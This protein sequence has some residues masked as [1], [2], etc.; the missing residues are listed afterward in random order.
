MTFFVERLTLRTWALSI[1]PWLLAR[2]SRAARGFVLDGSPVA[3]RVA[4]ASASLFGV[5]LERLRWRVDDVRDEHGVQVW[6]KTAYHDL[7]EVQADVMGEPVFREFVARAKPADRLPTYLAKSIATVTVSLFDPRSL[8]RALWLVQVCGWAARAAGGGAGPAVLFAGRRPWRR[9]IER[10]AA[11]AGLRL[12]PVAPGASPRRLLRRLLGPR[13]ILAIRA[14]RSVVARWR[15]PAAEAGGGPAGPRVA[16]EYYGHLNLEHPE[17][18]SDLFF[19][20]QGAL[21]GRDLLVSFGLPQDPLDAA[22][23]SELARHGIGALVVHPRAVAPSAGPVAIH[24]P[25]AKRLDVPRLGSGVPGGRRETAWLAEQVANYHAERRF[26]AELFAAHHVKVHVSWSNCVPLQCAIADAVESVGGVSVVYQRSYAELPLAETTIAA[27]IAFGYS[28]RVAELERRSASIIRYHVATGYLGDHRFPLLREQAR[29]LRATLGRRGATRVLAFFDENT[30]DDARWYLGHEPMRASYAFVLE[31]LLADASL[32]LVLKPKVPS[33]LRR[34]LGPV[35][36]LLARAEATGRCHVYEGGAIHGSHPPAAAA[37]AADLAIHGH[38][39]AATAGL[40]SALAGVPTLLLD[41]EGWPVSQLYRLGVGRVVFRDWPE[42]WAA[43]EERWRHPSGVPGLGDWTPLLD[44]LDPF[45]DG[46][47][48][49]R[50]GN[51]IRWLI[52]GFKGGLD[53][54]TVMAD[55]AELYAA[56]WGADKVTEVNSSV[57]AR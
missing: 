14:V 56:K 39:F 33:T 3:F 22:K 31:R 41:R 20:Q 18:Y 15:Q 8:W 44:D 5:A 26:W 30:V 43:V 50:M 46:R 28:A 54:E 48:A 57:K 36:T 42:L 49:E 40:E 45:R 21:P 23:A 16:V 52:D 17:R 55:A 9:S 25:T 35:A 10:Y 7:A 32:G 29:A 4:R 19:W 13:A 12:V 38:L 37:L 24:V 2:R 1:V 27:D 47:A 51:Y 34:R 53:R 6:M 11:R